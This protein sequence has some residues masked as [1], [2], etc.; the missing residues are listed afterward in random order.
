M[1]GAL[2]IGYALASLWVGTGILLG[3]RQQRQRLH[4]A[5][6][7]PRIRSSTD[8]LTR[9]L[10]GRQRRNTLLAV[11]TVHGVLFV[12]AVAAAQF[13]VP[14]VAEIRGKLGLRDRTHLRERY[15]D[16][17]LAGGFVESTIRTK[18]RSRFQQYRLT[19]K[20]RAWLAAQRT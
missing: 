13:L 12:M 8:S 10:E 5:E 17:A 20:G 16:P 3:R 18:P 11:L 4:A 15:L 7:P 1:P 2:G 14:R 6:V 19:A 9:D